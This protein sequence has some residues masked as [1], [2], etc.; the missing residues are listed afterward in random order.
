MSYNP[1]DIEPKWRSYWLTNNT[2]YC[3]TSDFSKPK[4]YIL[5]MFPFPS[6]QGLHVGHPEGY[7]ATDIVARMKRM[8][9]FNVLHPMGWDAFGLPAEQ[10]AIKNN[11]HP[12]LSTRRNID[13]FRNQIQMLGMSY[14]W[15]KEF[16]TIDSD[17]YKWTQWIF[18][19]LFEHDLAYVADIPVNFCPELGTVLANEEVVNGG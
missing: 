1:K 2:F 9:G 18:C 5:D 8:Q 15:S 4:Y 13:N 19:K 16:A 11:E 17:Y 10:F 7:T 12:E 14:D 6:A 3:D